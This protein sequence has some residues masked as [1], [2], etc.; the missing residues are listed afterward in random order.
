MRDGLATADAADLD[1][2]PAQQV[3]VEQ[4]A[5]IDTTMRRSTGSASRPQSSSRNSGHS[6]RA[7]RAMAPEVTLSGSSVKRA[8]QCRWPV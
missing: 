5:G 3:G 7:T 2:D 1:A 8:P 6:V 4:V